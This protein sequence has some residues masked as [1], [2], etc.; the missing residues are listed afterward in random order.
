MGLPS[1]LGDN[2]FVF[3]LG[4]RRAKAVPLCA[5]L[6]RTDWEETTGHVLKVKACAIIH[7]AWVKVTSVTERTKE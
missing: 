1:R 3:K 5:N 2:G 7:F 4:A 6:V